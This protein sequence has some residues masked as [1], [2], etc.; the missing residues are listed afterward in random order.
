[1][2]WLLAGLWHKIILV[3]FY[4]AEKG[5][6]HEGTLIIF[7]A[8]LVLGLL[9]TYLYRRGYKGD[10]PVMEGLLLGTVVGILW[11]FPNELVR[12]GAHGDSLSYVFINAAWHIIEQGSGGLLVGIL[13]K[14]FHR[15]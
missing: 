12:A 15:S 5:A 2:M 3:N 14:K 4:E 10:A 7:I 1:M 13:Y 8:Y 11:V 9:M 6:T